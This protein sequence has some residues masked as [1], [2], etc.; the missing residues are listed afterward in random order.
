MLSQRANTLLQAYT[1]PSRFW[2]LLLLLSMLFL[3]RCFNVTCRQDLFSLD[4]PK[5][6][7]SHLYEGVPVCPN[8]SDGVYCMWLHWS[9]DKGCKT[10]ESN[11]FFSP[12]LESFK[13]RWGTSYTPAEMLKRG[14]VQIFHLD[15]LSLFNSI[16]A[17]EQTFISDT[18]IKLFL[19]RFPCIRQV[20]PECST[21]GA[22][23]V[24][25]GKAGGKASHRWKVLWNLQRF[26]IWSQN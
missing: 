19:S 10:L 23:P 15:Y 4:F 21:K 11:I 26:T 3:S 8:W 22:S 24:M 6:L 14:S 12:V 7:L 20:V 18:W 17:L 5:L 2:P 9:N 1:C 16:I 25:K 13:K